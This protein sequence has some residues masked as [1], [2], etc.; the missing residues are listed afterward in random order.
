LPEPNVT[1]AVII[2]MTM[3]EIIGITLSLAI[4]LHYTDAKVC[5]ITGTI[6]FTAFVLLYCL[7]AWLN[8]STLE[9]KVERELHEGMGSGCK[10][11]A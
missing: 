5:A 6:L 8:R 4:P 3:I 10:K 7:G 2:A 11:C 9:D 1:G